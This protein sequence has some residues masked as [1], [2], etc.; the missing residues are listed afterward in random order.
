VT[1]NLIKKRLILFLLTLFIVSCNS[2]TKENNTEVNDTNTTDTLQT[3]EIISDDYINGIPKT[4]AQNIYG[5]RIVLSELN[6]PYD[7]HLY[8]K[9]DF[10]ID[11]QNV[12]EYNEKYLDVEGYQDNICAFFEQR[13]Q[14]ELTSFYIFRFNN[15]PLPDKFL[16]FKQINNKIKFIGTTEQSSSEIFG[17]VDLDGKFE[18]GG[19]NDYCE[20]VNDESDK[21]GHPFFCLDN[22]RIYEIGNS[23]DRDTILENFIIENKKRAVTLYKRNAGQ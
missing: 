6:D 13:E 5:T 17:D 22:L 18:I 16:V 3:K 2:L 4:V 19:F 23:F 1:L 14:G 7:L 12:F 15:R 21:S 11:N 9:I 8:G 10:F 20:P